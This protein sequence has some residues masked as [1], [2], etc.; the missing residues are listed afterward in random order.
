MSSRKQEIIDATR[1]LLIR[2]GSAGFSLRKV[3]ESLGISLGNLQ[4]YFR[5]RTQVL[6]ALLNEDIGAYRQGMKELGT[7]EFEGSQ[8][9]YE[10][11]KE[12]LL[13]AGQAEELEVFR[14]LFSFND[15]D[16]LESLRRYYEELYGLLEEGLAHISK[17][18]RDSTEV[19]QAACLLFP[20]LD[21]Y[22][23]TKSYL[24]LDPDEVAR[25]MT[26][27]VE[28]VLSF[29]GKDENLPNEG[30]KGFP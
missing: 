25:I 22:E 16:I 18:P 11:M 10:I 9:L 3:A 28:Q 4:Y 14:A 29:S 1:K 27:V 6:E 21:G 2:E 12:L 8:D 19:Q 15:P 20:F 24:P 5:T 7:R 23:T 17:K 26:K 13:E 30:T